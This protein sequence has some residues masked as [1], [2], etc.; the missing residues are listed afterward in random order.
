MLKNDHESHLVA[1]IPQLEIVAKENEDF[2]CARL[3]EAHQMFMADHE[4]RLASSVLQMDEHVAEKD[5]DGNMEMLASELSII[6]CKMG[7]LEV[8]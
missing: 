4:A 1:F 2:Y 3:H 7:L 5:Q 8:R 6:N